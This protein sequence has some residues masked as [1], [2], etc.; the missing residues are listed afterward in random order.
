MSLGFETETLEFKK[1]TGELKEGIISIASMLNKHSFGV[2]YFGVKNDGTPIGQ[3]IGD[4]T[5]RDISQAIAVFIKPQV[6]PTITLQLLDGK[7]IIK[8][9]AK[10]NEIPYSAYGKYYIRSADEDRELTPG[11]LRGLMQKKKTPTKFYQF[12]RL[13]KI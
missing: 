3:E 1:S 6:I 7:N 8:V 11:Q 9:E 12:V 10:G 4:S 5:L 2:L 13:G